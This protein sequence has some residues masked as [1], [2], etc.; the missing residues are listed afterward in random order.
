MEAAEK[1][2]CKPDT[3][4]QPIPP[5]Y[6]NWLTINKQ[7]FEQDSMTDDTPANKGGQ[8]NTS[9]I[10]RRL[11][12]KALSQYQG[13]TDN[14]DHFIKGVQTLLKQGRLAKK[15]A[16]TIKKALEQTL[17]PLKVLAILRKDI[18]HVDETGESHAAGN[19]AN[20]KREIILSAY[21]IADKN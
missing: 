2:Q 12:D 8:S 1:L 16:Q 9:Y 13:F 4:R 3:P 19:T 6:Y 20:A 21:Q 10:E 14:D 15:T 11:K 5:H 17:D 18:P 7:G